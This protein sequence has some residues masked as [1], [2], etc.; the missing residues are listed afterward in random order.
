M[1]FFN[2]LLLGA[3]SHVQ[4][5]CSYFYSSFPGSSVVGKDTASP[6]LPHVL[7]VMADEK[8]QAFLVERLADDFRVSFLSEPERVFSFCSHEMPDVILVDETVDT[9]SGEKICFCLKSHPL[10]SGIPLVLLAVCIDDKKYI[11]YMGCGAERVV[12][13]SIHVARLKA[14]LRSLIDHRIL[15]YKRINDLLNLP[16]PVIRKLEE[17]KEKAKAPFKERVKECVE[18]NLW[19]KDFSITKLC[20]AM[21]MSHTSLYTKMKE[22]FHM[23]PEEY[24]FVLKMEK[25]KAL[26]ATGEHTVED[27]SIMLDFCDAKYFGKRFKQFYDVSPSQYM[28]SL[29]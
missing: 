3:N 21:A 11:A 4:S 14:E 6:A 9:A 20:L 29:T 16:A 7:L 2:S 15:M 19:E 25:A 10:L 28:R 18:E 17:K 23:S 22:E 5:Y 8:L 27:V 1:L 26:L 24:V 13:R 12:S